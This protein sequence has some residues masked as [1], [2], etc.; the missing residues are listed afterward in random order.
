MINRGMTIDDL[1][2][3]LTYTENATAQTRLHNAVNEITKIGTTELLYDAAGNL[4]KDNAGGNGP[5]RYF[6]DAENRLTRIEQD[7]STL[8]ASYAYDA[9]GRRIEFIDH[10]GAVTK[11]FLY[12]ADQVIEEYNGAAT[13]ARQRY[14]IWGNYVDELLLLNDDAGDDSDYFVCYDQIYSSQALLSST[15]SIVERYDYDAYGQPVIYTGNGGDGD[16]WDGDETTS[17]TSAKGLV[18]LFTGREYDCLDSGGLK[19][20][21]YRARTY[22]PLLGRFLQR[23]PIGYGDGMNLYEYVSGNPARYLDPTGLERWN[24][25]YT[26]YVFSEEILRWVNDRMP[27]DSRSDWSS[28]II[29]QMGQIGSEGWLL[30]GTMSDPYTLIELYGQTGRPID[31]LL[32]VGDPFIDQSPIRY[33]PPEFDPSQIDMMPLGS[34][35]VGDKPTLYVIG[36]LGAREY[37]HLSMDYNIVQSGNGPTTLEYMLAGIGYRLSGGRGPLGGAASADG[38]EVLAGRAA[39]AAESEGVGGVIT[40]YTNHGLMSAIEHDGVGVS[41]RAILNAVRNP[42]SVV[43]QAGGRIR[44]VGDKAVVVVSEV[45]Q[46]ITTW[47]A[48]RQGWRLHP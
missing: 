4:T 38:V 22:H 43:L 1:G 48:T 41:P 15:G 5:Y 16:W 30:E 24:E 7:N 42:V 46:V 6:Y 2:N 33:V 40:G 39:A 18:Y 13:P 32:D 12:D 26:D 34:N 45:G 25:R 37:I 11:H 47:A 17:D 35:E 20:Y 36:Q 21:Y 23:D 14:Y 44:Y 19:L 8:V 3:W 10:P 31:P 9:L 29:R 28:E 27:E